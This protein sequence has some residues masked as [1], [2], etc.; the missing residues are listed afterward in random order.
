MEILSAMAGPPMP[1]APNQISLACNEVEPNGRVFITHA[2]L[3]Q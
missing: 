2:F 1:H 3:L